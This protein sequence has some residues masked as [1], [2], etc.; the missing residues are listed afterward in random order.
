MHIC[1]ARH[2]CK[3]LGLLRMHMCVFG[4]VCGAAVGRTYACVDVYSTSWLGWVLVVGTAGVFMH[5]QRTTRHLGLVGLVLDHRLLPGLCNR[6][7]VDTLRLTAG[8]MH[9]TGELKGQR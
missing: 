6:C 4:A 3:A 7:T 5:V 2:L 1:S 9:V 8:Y